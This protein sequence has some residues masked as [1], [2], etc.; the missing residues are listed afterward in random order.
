VSTF[1]P[2]NGWTVTVEGGSEH[3][4]RD[5]GLAHVLAVWDPVGRS[6]TISVRST[7]AGLT[8]CHAESAAAIGDPAAFWTAANLAADTVAAP[9]PIAESVTGHPEVTPEGTPLEGDITLRTTTGRPVVLTVTDAQADALS[10]ELHSI[11][12]HVW[13]EE[14]EAEPAGAADPVAHVEDELPPAEPSTPHAL[15]AI[16]ES[17]FGLPAHELVVQGDWQVFLILGEDRM[18]P[19]IDREDELVAAM[20]RS[21]RHEYSSLVAQPCLIIRRPAE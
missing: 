3:Y 7:Y 16:L 17:R 8:R 19:L 18:R 15:L 21:W 13:S 6:G 4:R 11:E 2:V 1:S 9:L 5:H 20:G 10:S 12:R 14:R